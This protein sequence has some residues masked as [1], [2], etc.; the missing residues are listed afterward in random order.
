MCY[1]HRRLFA[2]LIKH[3][4]QEGKKDKAAKAIAYAEKVL[5]VYN[6]PYNYMSGGVDFADAYYQ[7][8]KPKQAEKVIS[9][10][11]TTC[12]QYVAYYL[13]L[14]QTGFNASMRDCMYNFYIMQS[15]VEVVDQYNK[16][17]GDRLAGK[18]SEY[19]QIYQRRGGVFA[20]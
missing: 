5:P 14:N 9:Q 17:Y 3:L 8:G 12:A 4:L 7:L 13:T 6:L 15:M 10:M 2:S 20:E 1:T 11:F 18:I 16:A 19:M